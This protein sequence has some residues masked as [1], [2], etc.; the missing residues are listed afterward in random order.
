MSP[1][2]KSK[3]V[4]NETERKRLVEEIGR[5]KEVLDSFKYG[6]NFEEFADALFK[7]MDRQTIAIKNLDEKMAGI[8]SRMERLEERLNEG[9]KVRVS[10]LSGE[11][12]GNL[13]E[14]K[15]VIIEGPPV[16]KPS[17]ADLAAKASQ[18]DLEK[19]AANIEAKI[20]K[21]FEKE[22]DLLE[23]ALNDPAGADEYNGRAKVAIEM[24]GDLEVTLKKIKEQLEQF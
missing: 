4:I 7:T 6:L 24:R 10:G 23:M 17:E 21:L 22:N 9:I 12:T 19:E 1:E 18:E 11:T 2:N 14:G 13:A 5:I 3:S 15:E 8:V 16:Q 20:A